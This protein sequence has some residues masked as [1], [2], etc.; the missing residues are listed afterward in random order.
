MGAI[1]ASLL[2]HAD[3]LEERCAREWNAS[4]QRRKQ[5]REMRRADPLAARRFMFEQVPDRQS[6]P[7]ASEI[8]QLFDPLCSSF[9][10]ANEAEREEL[11]IFFR[12]RKRLLGNLRNYV[13]RSARRLGEAGDSE[14]LLRGLAAVVLDGGQSLLDFS[15]ELKRLYLAAE[16][17]GLQPDALYSFAG[18][19]CNAEIQQLLWR[20]TKDHRFSGDVAKD[21]SGGEGGEFMLNPDRQVADPS[22]ISAQM[23]AKVLRE[24]LFE[25]T[26]DPAVRRQAITLIGLLRSSGCLPQVIVDVL[27]AVRM[28]GNQSTEMTAEI[29]FAMGMQCGFELAHTYPGRPH[30]RNN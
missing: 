21:R 22:H 24:K 23:F 11:V 29:A 12:E 1:L 19:L 7:T 30:E 16:E 4:T 5:Y 18:E 28:T 9:F 13:A 8:D 20:F 25:N 27:A 6:T 3:A 10:R 14:Y 15:D 2:P 17:R 26:N